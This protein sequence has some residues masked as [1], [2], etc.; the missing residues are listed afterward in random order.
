MYNVL[1]THSIG[2]QRTGRHWQSSGDD[3]G[4]HGDIV[5]W[6]D[7]SITE[8]STRSYCHTAVSYLNMLRF[9][10]T[11]TATDTG[12]TI[13]PIEYTKE[14]VYDSTYQ[15][16]KTIHTFIFDRIGHPNDYNVPFET[17]YSK[18]VITTYK[19]IYRL[20]SDPTQSGYYIYQ[21]KCKQ[22]V[23][24][25]IKDVGYNLAGDVKAD[26]FTATT[27]NNLKN[28]I[29][30]NSFYDIDLRANISG[31][32]YHTGLLYAWTKETTRQNI[33]FFCQN[34][35]PPY[36]GD[37]R[38]LL[39][40]YPNTGTVAPPEDDTETQFLYGVWEGQPSPRSHGY[41]KYKNAIEF[42]Q[43]IYNGT[44]F[45]TYD[46]EAALLAT[47][48]GAGYKNYNQY[49]TLYRLPDKENIIVFPNMTRDY[50]YT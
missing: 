22:I 3:L 7:K 26:Y 1:N 30:L 37:F 40:D 18:I 17:G 20:S 35:N 45:T 28:G 8:Q 43:R 31:F 49:T 32:A 2:G 15:C 4:I 6:H 24:G 23:D 41:I 50:I 10:N 34:F 33:I 36:S 25:T 42:T 48:W 5:G 29:Y 14:L 16:Y 46:T 19:M 9:S 27:L 13:D 11:R 44:G 47:I 12:E 38:F 39:D 21:W